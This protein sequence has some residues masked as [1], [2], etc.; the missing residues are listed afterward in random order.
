MLSYVRLKRQLRDLIF[1]AEGREGVG[2]LFFLRLLLTFFLRNT[3]I[4]LILVQKFIFG[5]SDGPGIIMV[6]CNAKHGQ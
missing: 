5:V 3:S 6:V 2:A 1:P 4:V